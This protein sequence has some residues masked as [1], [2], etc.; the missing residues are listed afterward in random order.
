M[1]PPFDHRLLCGRLAHPLQIG[2]DPMQDLRDD[3]GWKG[4]NGFG[5]H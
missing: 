5:G 4:P 3:Q 1:E 2:S